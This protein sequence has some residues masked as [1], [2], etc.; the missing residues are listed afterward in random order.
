VLGLR[1]ARHVAGDI[2]EVRAEGKDQ[3]FRILFAQEGARGQ[4]L[5]AVDGFSKKT[6]RPPPAKVR[7]AQE[8][9]ADWRRRGAE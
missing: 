7:L 2:Y 6:R 4:V 1:A 3:S 9:L 8:R 5:L